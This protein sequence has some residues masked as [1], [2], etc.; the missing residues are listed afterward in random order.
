MGEA[1]AFLQQQ[2]LS[3]AQERELT[4]LQS[5][6][7]ELQQAIRKG[8]LSE[9]RRQ[10]ASNQLKDRLLQVPE[11][12]TATAERGPSTRSLAWI[13]GVVVALVGAGITV[14]VNLTA[15]TYVCPSFP[16]NFNNKVLVLPFQNVG[17]KPA[18]PHL[19]LLDRINTLTAKHQLS[20]IA[21]VGPER[22]ALT[23]DKA[24]DMAARCGAKV[25][26]WGTYSNRADSIY[27]NMQYYFTNAYEARSDSEQLQ[28]R[29]VTALQRGNMA[30]PLDD[31]I[32][33]LC[34]LIALREGDVKVA[35]KWFDKV[36]S[37]DELD[38]Q[39][40]QALPAPA[41]Q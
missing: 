40:L 30:K 33:S 35:R 36:K 14:Y 23:L 28:L 18:S 38:Q 26:V 8:I 41:T 9:D 22:S 13:L 21:R 16:T 11:R 15:N 39:V 25:L 3:K 32:F 20:T 19:V 34:G 7:Q 10:L 17:D 2:N 37:P 5:E 29:D 4:L 1:F 27:L 12:S 31:A 6:Y 24:P